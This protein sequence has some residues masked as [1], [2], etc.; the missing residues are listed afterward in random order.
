[1]ERKTCIG[2]LKQDN[3]KHDDGKPVIFTGK[4][5]RC[6]RCKSIY[7]KISKLDRSKRGYAGVPSRT[8]NPF[9]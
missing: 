5:T 7:N 6:T 2:C 9:R 8:P 1:M 3:E 4:Y